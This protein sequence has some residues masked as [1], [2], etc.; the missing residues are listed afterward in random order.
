MVGERL[1]LSKARSNFEVMRK[2][3]SRTKFLR[4]LVG[5]TF[6]RLR[7]ALPFRLRRKVRKCTENV[8]LLLRFSCDRL[9]N[10]KDIVRLPCLLFPAVKV[11]A[12]SKKS[13][14]Y[15]F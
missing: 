7:L 3:L 14:R 1:G 8:P 13:R 12:I 4:V 9:G 6:D 11:Y 10:R 2:R 5:Q 15:Q